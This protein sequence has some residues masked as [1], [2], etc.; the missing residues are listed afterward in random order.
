MLSFFTIYSYLAAYVTTLLIATCAVTSLFYITDV[1]EEYP[2]YARSFIKYAIMTIE[3]F[4]LCFWIFGDFSLKFVLIGIVAHYSYYRLMDTFPEAQVNVKLIASI[5]L[6]VVHSVAIYVYFDD[7]YEYTLLE[8]L[9]YAAVC[10]WLVPLSLLVSMSVGASLPMHY[11]FSTSG[12]DLSSSSSSTS[13]S[14]SSSRDCET[15]G[16]ISIVKPPI[17]K[18]RWNCKALFNVFRLPWQ[19]RESLLPSSSSS[20]RDL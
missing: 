18:V 8:E 15:S 4:H 2:G 16:K 11:D 7:A 12:T 1:C 9:L 13:T 20:T 3:G 10:S 6:F 5:A 19:K 17:Q 14:A